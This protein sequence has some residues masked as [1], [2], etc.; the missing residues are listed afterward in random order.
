MHLH[1]RLVNGSHC[2]G[3]TYIGPKQLASSPHTGQVTWSYVLAYTYL[4]PWADGHLGPEQ[5]S[6]QS[7]PRGHLPYPIIF[8]LL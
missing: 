5:Q 3:Q 4:S 7:P 1:G 6:P 2:L 8:F